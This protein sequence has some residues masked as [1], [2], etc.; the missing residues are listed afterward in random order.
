MLPILKQKS[1]TVKKMYS[2]KHVMY[3]KHPVYHF[4]KYF[5]RADIANIE[6]IL[7]IID[8]FEQTN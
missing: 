2:V 8:L 4:M 6:L 3:M 5:F 1:C 7:Y